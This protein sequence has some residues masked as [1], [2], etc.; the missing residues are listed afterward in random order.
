VDPLDLVALT[1]SLVDIDSTTGREADCGTW[2]AAYLRYL[3]W[4]VEEQEVSGGRSN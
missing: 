2:L 4:T 3:G 1:R